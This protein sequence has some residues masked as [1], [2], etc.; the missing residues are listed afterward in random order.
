M[1]SGRGIDV[2]ELSPLE[3][4]ALLSQYARTLDSRWPQPI[5]GDPL[6]DE[7]AEQIDFDFD[8]LGVPTSVVCQ[9]ALRT[10]MLDDRVRAFTSENPD[11][12]VVDLGAGLDS[13]PFRVDVPPTVDWYS[14]DLPG[15]IALRRRLLPISRRAHS[16]IA[17][18]ADHGWTDT[19][20]SQRP[21]M[22]IANGLFAFL[23]EPVIVGVF[24][25]L[26]EHFMSGELAFNEYG[27]IGWFSRAA[28]RLAPQRMFASVGAQW[29][30]PGFRDARVPEQ[31]NP[32]LTLVEE[33]S[34]THAPEIELFPEWIRLATKVSGMFETSARKARIL[35]YRF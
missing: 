13:G 19:I 26:T 16:L 8:G 14:I 23:P 17:S 32:K 10:K 35:R 5:L 2:S 24:R 28:V 3:Q 25:R 21:A 22:V 34:L 30:Y 11:A 15:V 29:G 6:A 12:V 9:S 20:P 4:T 1:R 27:R 7:I 31:W 18:V 33:A